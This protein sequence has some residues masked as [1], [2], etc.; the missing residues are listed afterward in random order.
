LR[1]VMVAHG[2]TVKIPAGNGISRWQASSA[3]DFPS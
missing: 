2:Q 1:V 3:T